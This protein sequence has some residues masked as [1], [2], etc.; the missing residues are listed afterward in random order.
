LPTP[1][2]KVRA[3]PPVED[4]PP[5]I[6]EP[7]PQPREAN[8]TPAHPTAPRQPPASALRARCAERWY[9]R[10]ACNW[11]ELFRFCRRS[12][13]RKAQRC[14]GEPTA[15]LRAGVQHAPDSVRQFVSSVIKAQ[16]LG[17]SFEEAFED[18][19]DYHDAYFAWVAGLQAAQRK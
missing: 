5:R 18:A 3:V 4:F 7:P 17:H 13:C 8:I 12:R 19:A 6:S 16:E 2:P 11:F 9:W 14:R 10:H 15:C 1:A